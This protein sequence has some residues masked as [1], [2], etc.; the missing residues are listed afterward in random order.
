MTPEEFVAALRAEVITSNQL[1]YRKWFMTDPAKARSPYWQRAL[2][3]FATLQEDQRE[4]F[5]QVLR[6]IQVDTVSNVLGIVDGSSFLAE[7]APQ[8]ELRVVG[9]AKLSGDLQ[10]YFLAQEEDD[11]PA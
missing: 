7:A 10:D 3:L 4:V 6:Q 2:A 11:S 1:D 8:L 9:G 5:F